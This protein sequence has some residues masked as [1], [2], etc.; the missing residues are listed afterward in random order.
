MKRIIVNLI[1]TVLLAALGMGICSCSSMPDLFKAEPTD[2]DMTGVPV[3]MV[4]DFL[5]VG[6]TGYELYNFR[7]DMADKYASVIN[8][9]SQTA[10]AG[11]RI[12]DILVPT[13]IDVTLARSVRDQYN[14]DDQQQAINYIYGNISASV[15]KV[16]VYDTLRLHRDEYIFFMTDHHYTSRGAWY[17]YI[18]FCN[19]AGISVA[20]LDND[21]TPTMFQNFHGSFYTNTNGYE[22]LNTPDYVVAY[23]PKA[24]NSIKITQSDGTPLDWNIVSDVSGWDSSS[25]YNAFIGGD[26]PWSVITN[27]HVTDG[28]SCIVIKESYG[29]PFVPYLVPNY[30]KIYVIDY[31]HYSKISGKHLSDIIAETGARDVIFINNMSMTR[32]SDLVGK[33]S[34]LVG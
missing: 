9:A 21:F 4:N 26:Q 14:T 34:G 27:D 15:N 7:Q 3:K 18:Q 30:N 2:P 22:T 33:L 23:I 24:T 5:I 12:F 17:T 20:D 32:S 19:A 31:R 29:N 13:A 11:T 10:P 28:S 25:L 16:D 8:K 1:S 6:N